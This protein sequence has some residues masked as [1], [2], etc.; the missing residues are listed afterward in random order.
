[1]RKLLLGVLAIST[2][3]CGCAP[4]GLAWRSRIW[5]ASRKPCAKVAERGR[6]RADTAVMFKFKHR[7]L[8]SKE[9]YRLAP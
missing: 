2:I 5:C 4:D 7:G 3:A 8:A 1:M 6:L 9:K